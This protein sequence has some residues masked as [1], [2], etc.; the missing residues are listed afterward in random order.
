MML[1]DGEMR[2][3]LPPPHRPPSVPVMLLRWRAELLV[4]G[5]V[6]GL[7]LYAGTQAMVWTAVVTV[8][9]AVIVRPFGRLLVGLLQGM[10]A[11]HRVRSGLIQAG[12]IDRQGR[13]PWIVA[14][15]PDGDLVRVSL[16]LN[17]GTTPDDLRAAAPVIATATGAAEVRVEQRSPRQDRAVLFVARPRWGWLTR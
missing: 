17:S 1:D 7:Y 9:L 16:W 15:R 3:L 11:S 2:R 14:Y 5:L 13:P 8:G 10:V 12:V 4:L 6:A